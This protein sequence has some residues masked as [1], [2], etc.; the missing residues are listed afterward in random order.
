MLY[1]NLMSFTYTGQKSG[2][3]HG[4]V[5]LITP[6]GHAHGVLKFYIRAMP[7]DMSHSYD[8]AGHAHGA[9]ESLRYIRA[10][11]MGMCYRHT[12]HAYGLV[13]RAMPREK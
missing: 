9:C 11:P 1:C 7:M 3:A 10:L 13:V 8:T 5:T 4:H 6:A 2:H 12:G